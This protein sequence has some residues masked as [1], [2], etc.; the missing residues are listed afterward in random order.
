MSLLYSVSFS[1]QTIAEHSY[2]T[3]NPPWSCSIPTSEN[4][5]ASR[6]GER[7][8]RENGEREKAPGTTF[9]SEG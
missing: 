2:T 9:D 1:T 8:H 5:F 3:W 4:I 7:A 6:E